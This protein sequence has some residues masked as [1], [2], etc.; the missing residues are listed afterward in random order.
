[1]VISLCR[2]FVHSQIPP[3]VA[4]MKDRKVDISYSYEELATG[5][6]VKIATTNRDA[7]NAVHDFLVFQIR[8][9]HTGDAEQP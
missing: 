1:M 9:H 5:G 4:E 6:R 7:L 3:G 2:I 8:D